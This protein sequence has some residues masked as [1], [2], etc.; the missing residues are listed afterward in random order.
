MEYYIERV[1]KNLEKLEAEYSE[2]A[3]ILSRK[4]HRIRLGLPMDDPDLFRCHN[5]YKD[6]VIL[7][8]QKNWCASCY[9]AEENR[10]ENPS[11]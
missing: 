1:R 7:W 5:C 8:S 11:G 10:E 6:S 4:L 3:P 9:E 2:L